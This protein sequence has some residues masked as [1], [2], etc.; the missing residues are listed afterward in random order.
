MTSYVT[1][2]CLLCVPYQHLPVNPSKNVAFLLFQSQRKGVSPH[3]QR[4][5]MLFSAAPGLLG[6]GCGAEGSLAPLWQCWEVFRTL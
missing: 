1:L 4:V 6:F 3:P 2:G 5:A